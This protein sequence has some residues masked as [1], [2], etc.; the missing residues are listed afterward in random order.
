MR[1]TANS[2][3]RKRIN[4][5]RSSC[6]A[7]RDEQGDNSSIKSYELRMFGQFLPL[8]FK[9]RRSHHDLHTLSKPLTTKV[10]ILALAPV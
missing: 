5:A 9:F 10:Q 8:R 1:V 4:T 3:G 2:K 6:M 7:R